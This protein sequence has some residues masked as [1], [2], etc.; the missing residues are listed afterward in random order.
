MTS[1]SSPLG[2]YRRGAERL[3]KILARLR[4][5]HGR[6]AL[7][8]FAAFLVAVGAP[9]VLIFMAP[10]KANALFVT[11][12]VF[13]GT[14]AFLVLFFYHYRVGDR[15]RLAR[16]HRAEYAACIRR[17]EPEWYEDPE[18]PAHPREGFAEIVENSTDHPYGGDLNVFGRFS[19]FQY[20]NRASTPGGEHSLAR[21]LLGQ[22]DEEA[23]DP[24]AL[25]KRQSVTRTLSRLRVL[26]FR[27]RRRG[28]TAE[29][30]AV[31]DKSSAWLEDLRSAL[32]PAYVSMLLWPAVVF[33]VFT[34]VSY[35]AFAL[36]LA[37]PYFVLTLPA[38]I[39]L[40][41]WSTYRASRIANAYGTAAERL[42][43]YAGLLRV[44]ARFKSRGEDLAGFSVFAGAAKGGADSPY[45]RIQTLARLAGYFTFR[46]NPIVHAVLG[47]FFVYEL[48]LL[49]ALE[50]WRRENLEQLAEWLEDLSR[51]DAVLSLAEFAADHPDFHWPEPVEVAPESEE[52][53]L[54]GEELSHPLLGP[55]ER[56]GNSFRFDP[57]HALWLISGS[58]MSGKST[59][60]RS[61]GTALLLGMVGAP[62]AAKRFRFR[63]VRL[64]TS[65]T[66]RDDLRRSLSLFYSEVK[67]IRLILDEAHERRPPLFY[68]IDEMLH[69]TNSRERNIACR[70]I[71]RQLQDRGARGMVTTH[72]LDLLDLCGSG[73]RIYCGHFE[74]VIV[75][76]RMSFD[77]K[78][79]EGPVTRSNALRILEMEGIRV[80]EPN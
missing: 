29:F 13:P 47:I 18:F 55:E 3:E 73:P 61:V 79:K 43:V 40:F 31:R 78:L 74:E 17:L 59:F 68:L 14:I 34:L 16:A 67:R 75:E 33:A 48:F 15:L 56:V 36:E 9:S 6:T 22:P 7:L 60:L 64:W 4:R 58:N 27:F 62:V 1:S 45:E 2:R 5:I 11:G 32:P 71:M 76:D 42:E 23:L 77:Y 57:E 63:P 28:R 10:E 46:K 30:N 51:F 24:G 26:R 53:S 65:I 66:V 52:F 8:R 37:R 54:E 25:R 20:I 41:L 39:V 35:F 44:C 49:R 50:R 19:L 38:Q 70:S 80:D 12:A 21:M 72:D 69:G